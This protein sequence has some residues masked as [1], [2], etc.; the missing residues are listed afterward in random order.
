MS[1]KRRCGGCKEYKFPIGNSPLEAWCSDECLNL[2]IERKKKQSRRSAIKKPE[3]KKVKKEKPDLRYH[4]P[5]QTRYCQRDFNSMISLL[6]AGEPC[7]S[8]GKYECGYEF[9]CGHYKSVASNPEL[10]FDPRNAYRQGGSC[11]TGK[12]VKHRASMISERYTHRLTEKV[13]ID[14]VR[15]LNSYQP[16]KNYNCDDLRELAAI[17]RAESKRLRGGEAPSVDWRCAEGIAGVCGSIYANDA[18]QCSQ[19]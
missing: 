18:H 7:I 15:Y 14:I 10:R 6:D 17:F 11:N 5:T 19:A 2:I 8:C 3:P 1:K 12:N 16:L 4:L 9:H 13:G